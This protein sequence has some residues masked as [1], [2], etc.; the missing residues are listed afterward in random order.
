M[1][2]TLNSM[3]SG[4]RPQGTFEGIFTENGAQWICGYVSEEI[5]LSTTGLTT[6]STANLLP[7][8]SVIEG[9]CARVTTT[10]TL[11]TSWAVGDGTTSARFSSANATLVAGTTSVG[12]NHLSG[13]STTLATGPSQ[14]SAA[15]VR[16]T[17]AGA[18]PGAGKIRITV[19]YRQYITSTS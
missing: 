16:I 4:G 10:I 13:A 12:L 15:P 14:V 11:T 1:A 17:C 8:N 9:V 19:F 7:A 5:T 6:D 18:N 2:N 3:V